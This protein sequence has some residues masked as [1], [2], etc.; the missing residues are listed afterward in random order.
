MNASCMHAPLTRKIL[1]PRSPHHPSTPCPT[2]EEVAP[3][4]ADSSRSSTCLPPSRPHISEGGSCAHVCGL[5]SH[6]LDIPVR[7]KFPHFQQ[8]FL[9]VGRNYPHRQDC[10]PITPHPHHVVRSFVDHMSLAMEF[11]EPRH[12]RNPNRRLPA[13]TPSLTAVELSLN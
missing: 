7:R 9:K 12:T 11:H 13:P 10:S 3:R 8:G 2:P 1:W 4:A 6:G 5:P